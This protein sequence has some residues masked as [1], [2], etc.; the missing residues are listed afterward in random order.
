MN[1]LLPFP[2]AW[3]AAV[4]LPTL[5]LAAC[6]GVPPDPAAD[7]AW[8]AHRG[9]LLALDRWQLDGRLNI[10]GAD[11]SDTVSLRWDQRPLDFEINLSGRLGLG[12]VRIAGRDGEV[13][14]EKAGEEPVRAASL[15]ELGASYLGYA[16]PARQLHYW[17]RGIDAPGT[18][19][20]LTLNAEERLATLMQDGWTLEY[21]RYQEAG[22]LVLPGRIRLDFN[23]GGESYRLTFLIGEWRVE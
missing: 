15:E 12:S 5:L 22:G 4:L 20:R 7:L 6:A 9:A 8:Q 14:V 21:D 13:V 2:R 18:P 16:F 11:G 23:Q 10:R 19:A 17:I 3:R 1:A